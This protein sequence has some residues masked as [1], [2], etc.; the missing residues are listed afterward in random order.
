[1]KLELGNTYIYL[2]LNRK[3]TCWCIVD[4]GM[5]ATFSSILEFSYL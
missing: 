2:R 3:H 4:T 1:M 5:V